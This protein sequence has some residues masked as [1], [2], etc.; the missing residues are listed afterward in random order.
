MKNGGMPPILSVKA[1]APVST[2]RTPGAAFAAV[3]VDALDRRMRVRRKHR[4]A[5]TLPGKREVADILAGAGCEALILDPADGLSDAELRH[6]SFHKAKGA[7]AAAARCR[8]AEIIGGP[9]SP[10]KTA[11]IAPQTHC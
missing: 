10:R 5:I 9:A 8:P 4:Y 3:D 2:Q 6:V 1:S 7:E 11:A